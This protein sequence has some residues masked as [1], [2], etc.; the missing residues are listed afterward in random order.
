M[1]NMSDIT[2][3]HMAVP[4]AIPIPSAII[5][6]SS[7]AWFYLHQ[8]L[9]KLP[10]GHHVISYIE[11]ATQDD[12][13]RTAVEASLILY[14]IYYYLSKPQQKKGL[15]SNRP[16]LSKQE[17]DSLIDEW[18]PEPIVVPPINDKETKETY[19]R[20][21]KIPIIENHGISKYIDF[22]RDDNKESFENVLNLA[23][24]NF[25]SLSETEEV[26]QVAKD[27]IKNYGVGACGPAG[28]YGNQDVHYNLEYTLAEFFGTESCCLYGQDFA[29]SSSVIPAFTKRGDVIV[30]DDQVSLAVQNALQLSRSTVYYFQH[31][32]ME[33]LEG[34]LEQL[35]DQER[36]ENLPAIPRKFIVTEGLFHNS[37]DVA[38]LPQLVELKRKYKYRLFVDETL[39]LGVLGNTG[40][41]L[42]EQFNLDRST[43][44]D[45]TVGSMAT[46]FGSSGGFVLGDTFMSE[47]QHIG[48]NA[49]CF[50][51]SLPAYTTTVVDKILHIMDDDNSTVL[52]LQKLSRTMFHFFNSRVQLN[53]YFNITSSE[54]SPVL[55]LELKESKRIE[56]FGYSKD[57]LFTE[58]ANLQKRK[59]SDVFIE[60]FEN[61]EIFLQQIVDSIL[62]NHNILI[63]RHTIVL[64]QET[65]PIVPSLRISCT[66][67]MTEDELLT[68]CENIITTINKLCTA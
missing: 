68:A 4:T 27:T 7:A 10:G 32:N 1:S 54:F 51:A 48:S 13:Y 34:L 25:L 22:T 6:T 55:H 41:G 36:K 31:N 42:P 20:L 11:K 17:I 67:S 15:Q 49:Y 65:L 47:Y 26:L 9:S 18:E 28:F 37:G 58:L 53:E 33:S 59:I 45:I 3:G 14:G 35:N 23:S 56:R 43:S 30:A 46:A 12:P 38:P 60:P 2:S 50:S 40:R 62:V 52:N 64:K 21:S 66:A 44:I 5:A 19:W 63:S 29:V 57:T 8:G 24:N 61:E 39:S 16:N